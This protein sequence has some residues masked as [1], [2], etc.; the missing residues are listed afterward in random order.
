MQCCQLQ[1]IEVPP[2]TPLKLPGL[3]ASLIHLGTQ[4]QDYID[5]EASLGSDEREFRLKTLKNI[6]SLENNGFGDQLD[7]MQ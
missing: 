7:G 6:E 1:K 4:A 3:P 5:F 2:E